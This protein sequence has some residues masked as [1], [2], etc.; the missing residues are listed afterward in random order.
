MKGNRKS[1]FVAKIN[2]LLKEV[3]FYISRRGGGSKFRGLR[4]GKI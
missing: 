2:S 3:G 1:E 4:V